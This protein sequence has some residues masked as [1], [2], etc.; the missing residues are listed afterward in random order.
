MDIQLKLNALGFLNGIKGELGYELY[1]HKNDSKE[2]NNLANNKDYIKVFDSLKLV[3]DQRISEASIK[4][5]GL[6][7]QFE[8]TKPMYKAK[9]Y[10]IWRYS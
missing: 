5:K 7:R 3:I 2:L 1:D 9:K 10:N 4:P 6:G 8:N